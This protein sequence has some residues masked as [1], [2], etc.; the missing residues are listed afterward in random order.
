MA[1][2]TT[3]KTAEQCETTGQFRCPKCGG[4]M[5]PMRGKAAGKGWNC[6]KQKW[7]GGDG[8]CDGVIWNRGSVQQ[9]VAIER[10]ADWL[11]L[12]RPT[13]EGAAILAALG[14]SPQERGGRCVI[15]NAGPGTG[16]STTMAAAAREIANRVKLAG[17]MNWHMAAF[18]VNAR[19]SLESKLPASWANVATINGFGG[20]QQGYQARNYKPSKVSMIFRDLVSHIPYKEKPRGAGLKAFAERIRDCLLYSSDAGDSRFWTQAIST[21]AGRFPALSKA[22]QKE[23][24]EEVLREYLPQVLTR[25]LADGK[26]IDLTEQ[27]CKPAL[28]A[29]ARTGW[30]MRL[31]CVERSHE[32][33]EDDISH[34][35]GLIR[36]VQVPQVAG[37]I[38][39]EAQDLSLSQIVLFLAS[40][41]RNGE[42]ILVGDD[43]AGNPGEEGYKAGQA[44]FGW[45]G[46]FPGSFALISRL[47]ECLTQETPISLNLSVSFRCPPE[48]CR[49]VRGL[50]TI[51]TSAKEEGTGEVIACGVQDAYTRWLDLPEGETALWITR[52]NAPLA[53]LFMATLKDRKKVCLRG[54]G[55]MEA[56]VNAALYEAAGW[57]DDAGEFRVS[58]KDCLAK[59]EELAGQNEGQDGDSMEAFLL[60]VGTEIYR[61]PSLLTQAELK[62][63]ATVGNL[64]RF[65]LYFASKSAPRVL[66]TV[67]RSKGDE[68]DLVIVDDT[69]ALNTAWNG[70]ECEAAACRHVAATRSKKALLI[71]G[72]LAGVDPS[73]SVPEVKEAPQE[74]EPI[75][76]VSE[77]PQALEAEQPATVKPKRTSKPRKRREAATVQPLEL[78]ADE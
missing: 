62:A 43:R 22:I 57:Y 26:A 40:T 61:D 34:L 37:V 21:I 29:I 68:A 69:E 48:I 63:E 52:R 31:E 25:A 18:N 74:V 8:S 19:Q 35:C 72:A 53:P 75:A 6:H 39:D 13:E 41:W 67:Y 11:T 16:K 27:Y 23:G 32:W 15:V 3:N 46:A 56:S 54:G 70:D 76:P 12:S 78:F 9:R 71:I 10:P 51:L 7:V 50:N 5:L 14:Q 59:L 42:L 2:N 24:A 60:T 77:E 28:D 73:G 47:W 55:D 17:L 36:A 33:T 64:R 45:R 1:K 30:R 65:V 20:R 44:I 4:R 38:V 49:A 66:S 58:L